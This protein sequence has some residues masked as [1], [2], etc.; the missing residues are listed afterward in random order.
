VRG[1]EQFFRVG[2]EAILEP[3]NDAVRHIL[4]RA[5][6]RGNGADAILEASCQN[7][8]QIVS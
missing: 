8:I 6:S 2:P 5:A 7:L 4:E 1:P 3:A